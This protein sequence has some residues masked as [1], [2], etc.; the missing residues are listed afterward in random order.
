MQPCVGVLPVVLGRDSILHRQHKHSYRALPLGRAP[1]LYRENAM[2]NSPLAP[3]A[4]RAAVARCLDFARLSACGA[5]RR[6]GLALD[7]CGP[8]TVTE[9]QR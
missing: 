8:T 9:V 3:A 2:D 4:V 7:A 5:S 6:A 1:L